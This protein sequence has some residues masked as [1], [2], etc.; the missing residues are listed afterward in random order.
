LHEE[1]FL[2]TQALVASSS[3]MPL[4]QHDP[5]VHKRF[6]RNL[7]LRHFEEYFRVAHVLAPF[8]F[9][10]TSFNTTLIFTALHFELDGYFLLFLEN[11]KPD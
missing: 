7:V 3:L 8:S 9:T 2:R 11:Y 10:T 4:T 6:F 5:L 1:F